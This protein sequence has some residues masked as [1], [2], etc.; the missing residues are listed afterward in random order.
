VRTLRPDEVVKR[1]GRT[2]NAV[3]SRRRTLGL[4]DGRANRRMSMTMAGRWTP[5]ENELIKR[6][7]SAEAAKRLDR[8]QIAVWNRRRRY[9][10][11]QLERRVNNGRKSITMSRGIQPR[12][13]TTAR[14]LDDGHARHLQRLHWPP[15][16]SAWRVFRPGSFLRRRA[17]EMWRYVRGTL[18]IVTARRADTG[19]DRQRQYR[20]SREANCSSHLTAISGQGFWKSG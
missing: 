19:K 20:R 16:S 1:T 14:T 5:E 9:A 4:P 3:W 11:R 18:A 15:L 2:L 12:R 7:P 10:V 8:T 17:I 6:L 13:R